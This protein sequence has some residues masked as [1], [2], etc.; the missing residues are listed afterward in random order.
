MNGKKR[1][2]FILV[3]S[4]F[5]IYFLF[6][7]PTYI[8]SKYLSSPY[9]SFSFLW[10]KLF[11]FL[12]KIDKIGGFPN[13]AKTFS[14]NIIHKVPVWSI[15]ITIITNTINMIFGFKILRKRWWYYLILFLSILLTVVLIDC[16]RLESSPE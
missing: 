1:I 9:A 7:L 5:A 16:Y 6:C 10:E 12:F 2:G 11:L 4:L 3:F 8:S 14:Y 13:F 15:P